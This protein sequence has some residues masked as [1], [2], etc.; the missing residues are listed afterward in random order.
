MNDKQKA[1]FFEELGTV[2]ARYKTLRDMLSECDTRLLR[3]LPE[4]YDAYASEDLT[5]EQQ[6]Q[7]AGLEAAITGLQSL[8]G[9][10]SKAIS[11]LERQIESIKGDSVKRGW[12]AYRKV[13]SANGSSDSTAANT[14]DAFEGVVVKCTFG[15]G[16]TY[17]V[18]AR[19]KDTYTVWKTDPNMPDVRTIVKL[20]AFLDGFVLSSLTSHRKLT[21]AVHNNRAPV[22]CKD[23]IGTRADEIDGGT[24]AQIVSHDPAA[25]ETAQRQVNSAKAKAK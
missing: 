4:A 11:P 2:F 23:G 24:L 8:P 20:P 1:K 10:M 12:D 17:H 18:S 22:L 14:R 13:L 9:D 15:G 21:W 6:Q 7:I 16:N 5:S 3:A 19:N 25:W